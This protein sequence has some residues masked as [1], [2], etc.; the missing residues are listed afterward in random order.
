MKVYYFDSKNINSKYS[1]CEK[2]SEFVSELTCNNK[3]LVILC[4]GTDRS[5]GDSLGPLVGYKL[6][7]N[8][9]FKPVIYGTLKF[10]VHAL[11][12]ETVMEQINSNHPNSV[13][14]AIDASTGQKD[15]V[16]YITLSKGPLYPGLALKK[17]L[18]P[19]GHI[20]ITG[21]VNIQSVMNN[22]VLQTTRL[23]TVMSL[24]DL[25]STGISNV[26]TTI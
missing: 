16:G 13:I 23:D 12:L 17:Q 2:L 6:D 10:P 20:C 7:S 15:H 14:I 4:I 26:C 8:I 9:H 19:V 22:A 3:E 25:I 1:F 21:I 18:L 11:N 24:A 5:T